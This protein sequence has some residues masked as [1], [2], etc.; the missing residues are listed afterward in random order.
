M[1]NATSQSTDLTLDINLLLILLKQ[2]HQWW[3]LLHA[4]HSV[5]RVNAKILTV[6]LKEI[7]GE[8]TDSRMRKTRPY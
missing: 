6:E 8:V 2:Q 4:I 3:N 1:I 5:T 7:K